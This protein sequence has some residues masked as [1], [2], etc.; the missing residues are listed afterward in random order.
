MAS[1]S[2]LPFSLIPSLGMIDRGVAG[3]QIELKP[4]ERGWEAR[5]KPTGAVLT[6]PK[7]K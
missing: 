2:H 1:L 4:V 3:C 5:R 7:K 6:A